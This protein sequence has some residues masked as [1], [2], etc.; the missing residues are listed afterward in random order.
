MKNKYG[1]ITNNIQT[2]EGMLHKNSKVFVEE[3]MCKCTHGEKNIR[4][5]DNA[6]RLFWI[7]NNDILVS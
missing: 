5:R 7:S 2:S 4:V 6:G 3:I 1:Q